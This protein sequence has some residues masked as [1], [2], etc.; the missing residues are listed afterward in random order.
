MSAD[1]EGRHDEIRSL[2]RANFV[3]GDANYESQ[4]LFARQEF[5]YGDV[6]E[7]QRIFGS[8]RESAP[9]I[10]TGDMRRP[11]LGSDGSPRF[12][13]GSVVAKHDSYCFVRPD[14]YQADIFVHSREFAPET[15]PNIVPSTRVRFSLV[16]TM[17]G[18][19]GVDAKPDS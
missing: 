4:Y 9:N 3:E 5:V 14:L 16:F 17:R 11:I 2:L 6:R 10:V 1:A 7:A 15:W 13:N 8:L 19:A 18:A 12:F